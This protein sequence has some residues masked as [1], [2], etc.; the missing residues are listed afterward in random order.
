MMYMT[1]ENKKRL[2]Q[3][4]VTLMAHLILTNDSP[5][6]HGEDRHTWM[7]EE[8][9]KYALALMKAQDEYV[10]APLLPVPPSGPQSPLPSRS[11]E[12]LVQVDC[13]TAAAPR[14][15]VEIVD[16]D[17]PPHSLERGVAED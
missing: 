13:A 12:K 1:P 6:I 5:D 16:V 3:T 11:C 9:V 2:D 10:A 7:A 14:A 15:P 17:R 8:A 4:S